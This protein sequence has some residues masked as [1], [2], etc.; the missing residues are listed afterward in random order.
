MNPDL[1]I[2]GCLLS[3]DLSTIIY[4]L[5]LDFPAANFDIFPLFQWKILRK[6]KSLKSGGREIQLNNL[7]KLLRSIQYVF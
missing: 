3:K 5:K 7:L 6:W 2:P 1:D 4:L